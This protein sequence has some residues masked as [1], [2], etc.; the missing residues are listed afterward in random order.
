MGFLDALFSPHLTIFRSFFTVRN[1]YLLI[2]YGDYAKGTSNTADPYI[3]L[4]STT[5]DTANAHQDFVKLRLGGK[6]TTTNKSNSTSSAKSNVKKIAIIGGAVALGA[7]ALLVGFCL[8]CCRKRGARAPL[9]QGGVM[10]FGGQSYRPLN[11]P[12]PHAAVETHAM[13]NLGY[14]QGMHNQGPPAYGGQH[15]QG[16]PENYQT[17]WDHRF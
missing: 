7:I 2:N 4:L 1:A 17:A 3:Q 16:G 15:P 10:G 5:N 6:D 12:A 14:N 8:C 11:D 9:N 13:P